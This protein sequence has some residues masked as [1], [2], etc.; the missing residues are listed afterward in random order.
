M[1][2]ISD[3]AK[4]TNLGDVVNRFS[5]RSTTFRSPISDRLPQSI[6]PSEELADRFPDDIARIIKRTGTVISRDD[7]LSLSQRIN[8]SFDRFE[9]A[10]PASASVNG[11][12]LSRI[13]HYGRSW[14][15]DSALLADSMFDIGLEKEGEDILFRIFKFANSPQQRER[16]YSN[17]VSHGREFAWHRYHEQDTALFHPHIVASRNDSGD[18]SP[19]DVDWGHAQLDGISLA[20]WVLFRRANE[21]KLNL[22][23][24]NERLNAIDYSKYPPA[25]SGSTGNFNYHESIMVL[26]LKFLAYTNAPHQPD[27]GSWE[28]Y[29]HER[30]LSVAAATTAAALEAKEHFVKANWDPKSTLTVG[31]ST[32][33]FY[34]DLNNLISSGTWVMENRIPTDGKSSA[35]ESDAQEADGS[36]T[37]IL[38]LLYKTLPLSMNQQQGLIN[39]VHT[40]ERDWGTVRYRGDPYLAEGYT[41]NGNEKLMAKKSNDASTQEATWPL[42]DAYMA[43]YCFLR[44]GKGGYINER[45]LAEGVGH[46]NRVFSQVTVPQEVEHHIHGMATIDGGFLPE[47]NSLDPKTMSAVPTA[48]AAP[49]IWTEAATVSATVEYLGALGFEKN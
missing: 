24:F 40:L 12:T 18:L 16:F 39:G 26:M 4:I 42:L 34:D 19:S 15:R 14:Y 37:W 41:R 1:L 27:F 29:R 47:A 23:E 22:L 6:R 11:S 46:L 48:H 21:K 43:K 5:K 31:S 9:G 36:F 30:R 33:E 17:F 2:S 8:L 10:R 7:L 3:R 20:L 32:S 45:F 35:R 44:F 38:G 25:Q 13:G 49:L 28:E